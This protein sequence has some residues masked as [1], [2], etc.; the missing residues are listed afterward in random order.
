[1]ASGM[2]EMEFIDDDEDGGMRR[3]KRSARAACSYVGRRE[4]GAHGRGGDGREAVCMTGGIGGRGR[5]GADV[6]RRRRRRR[7][8]EGME[9]PE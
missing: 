8:S 7:R 6:H 5:E 2:R 3:R 1:M 4:A 9:A